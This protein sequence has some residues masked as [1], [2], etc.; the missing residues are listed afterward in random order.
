L[1]VITETDNLAPQ[2]PDTSTLDEDE[3]YELP[4]L[5][6]PQRSG[7]SRPAKVFSSRNPKTVNRHYRWMRDHHVSGAFLQ[8]F[9]GGECDE[10][11]LRSLQLMSG[12]T[13]EVKNG[14]NGMRRYRDDIVHRVKEASN[15]NGRVVSLRR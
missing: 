8:R 1:Q 10:A 2:W 13:A 7:P 6:I 15:L 9:L 4:G 5:S 14:D 11:S 12:W 3:L